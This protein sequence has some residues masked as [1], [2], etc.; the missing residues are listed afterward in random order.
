[1][2]GT[3]AL[4]NGYIQRKKVPKEFRPA[5]AVTKASSIEGKEAVAPFGVG[6][7]VV[8]S[9]FAGAPAGAS[10]FASSSDRATW[11]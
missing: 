4:N 11:P 7:V 6:Q 5:S 1:M 3:D 10:N 2:N 8:A 9:M